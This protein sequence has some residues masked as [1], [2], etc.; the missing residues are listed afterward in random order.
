MYWS[1][2]ESFLTTLEEDGTLKVSTIKHKNFCTCPLMYMY[3]YVSTLYAVMGY[4]R[5]GTLTSTFF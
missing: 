5:R 1:P 3:M 2:D 4:E